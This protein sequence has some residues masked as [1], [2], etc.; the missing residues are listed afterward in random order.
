M[1]LPSVDLRGFAASPFKIWS[2]IAFE[3]MQVGFFFTMKV[4]EEEN[5]LPTLVFATY[6]ECV[7]GALNRTGATSVLAGHGAYLRKCVKR[8]SQLD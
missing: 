1:S 6:D 5:L 3:E 2:G 4:L 7:H 8:R